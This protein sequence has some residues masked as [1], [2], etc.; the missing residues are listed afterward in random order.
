MRAVVITKQGSPVARNVSFVEDWPDVEPAA[1]QLRVR[2]EAS[3]LN[4]LD[5]WVGRGLPGVDRPFPRIA[6]SDGCGRVDAVGEGVDPAWQGRRVVLNAAVV[7]PDPLRPGRLPTGG[8]MRVIGEHVDGTMRE[9]FVA[10]VS[11]VLDVGDLDAA[12]A[13]ASALTHLT[14]WR[15]LATRARIQPGQSVLIPGIGGGVALA[16]L[17]IARHFGC[18]TIVTSRHRQKL[19]RALALGADHAIIDTGEDWSQQVRQLTSKRGVDICADSVGQ[20]IHLA[21]L[22]SLTRGGVYVTCGCTSGPSATTDLARIFWNQL[23]V[24]GSTMGDMGEFREVMA[25]CRCGALTPVIDGR[26]PASDAAMAYERLE[27]G[28]QFGKIVVD[29]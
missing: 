12:G 26:F 14:A 3:A 27:S 5:L 2:T 20:A 24:L 21:C 25:L 9:H 10:P 6:G 22:H 18:T 13:A 29:W 15:M 17:G 8:S 7:R 28:A 19:E 16:L 1:G 23:S 11:N 4:H